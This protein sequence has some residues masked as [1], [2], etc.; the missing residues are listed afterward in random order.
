MVLGLVLNFR[1]FNDFQTSSHLSGVTSQMSA[2]Q[3][4]RL[5]AMSEWRAA[6]R[7]FLKF[8]SEKSLTRASKSLNRGIP[9]FVK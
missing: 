1:K 9:I 7:I 2:C 6:E 4:V 5:R 8:Q 3:Y